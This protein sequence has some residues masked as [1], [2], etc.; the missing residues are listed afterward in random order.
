MSIAIRDLL[1]V[2][3]C[4]I[5]GRDLETL[6]S[7][8]EPDAPC[9]RDGE[10]VGEGPE[11]VRRLLQQE[12]AGDD[13]LAR[14]GHVAGEPVI[15]EFSGGEGRWRAHGALRIRGDPEDGRIRELRL[16]HDERIVRAA[17]PEP[18]R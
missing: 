4:A 15:L 2:H 10:W 1:R 6:A 7:H 9:F 14:M 11:G 3:A 12:V 17:V 18:A 13:F 8:A 16:T 5:N